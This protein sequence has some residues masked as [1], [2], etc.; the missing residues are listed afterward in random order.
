MVSDATIAGIGGCGNNGQPA[1]RRMPTLDPVQ[2]D[3]M[4]NNNIGM[5]P[6]GINLPLGYLVCGPNLRE[7]SKT[8]VIV[9]RAE[10]S[11]LRQC[12]FAGTDQK[13]GSVTV[14][15][16]R[17]EQHYQT[18]FLFVARQLCENQVNN[19]RQ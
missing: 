14:T 1:G 13:I 6:Q 7:I 8:E 17:P 12:C 9:L 15:M 10:L 16:E 19:H 2:A 5:R 11:K 18:C 3:G 4:H